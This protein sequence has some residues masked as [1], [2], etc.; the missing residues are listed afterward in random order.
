[1]T[2]A[3]GSG[4]DP[5]GYSTDPS[6]E[7]SSMDRVA[8]HM[9]VKEPQETYGFNGFGTT[10]QF[11]PQANGM[12][13]QQNGYGAQRG[14]HG[15]E[16]GP[17]VPRKLGKATPNQPMKLGDTSGNAGPPPVQH[18]EVGEKRKSW[19]GKRFSKSK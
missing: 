2:T 5:I 6:S 15:Y 9:P 10:P 11:A 8:T 4:S 7:N 14:P 3:S 19:F 18:P 17:Q 16:Q 1:V 12:S 13:G